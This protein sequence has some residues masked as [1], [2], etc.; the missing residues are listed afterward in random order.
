MNKKLTCLPKTKAVVSGYRSF[1]LSNAILLALIPWCPIIAVPLPENCVIF[2]MFSGVLFQFFFQISQIFL[3]I[4]RCSWGNLSENVY[5]KIL[6]LTLTG[7]FSRTCDYCLIIA[8]RPVQILLAH[9]IVYYAKFYLHD[10]KSGSLEHRL[11]S[12]RENCV[13]HTTSATWLFY[14]IT[15]L[16]NK[17]ISIYTWQHWGGPAPSVTRSLWWPCLELLQIH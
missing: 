1:K 6:L 9:C 17:Y 10:I 3:I 8:V 4:L 5:V 7:K 2:S 11:V 15:K 12:F 16:N 13:L 14:C